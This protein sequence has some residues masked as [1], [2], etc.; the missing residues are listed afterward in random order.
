MTVGRRAA[1]FPP[2]SDEIV[3]RWSKYG[4]WERVYFPSLIGM[5]I[6]EVRT[7]YCRMRLPFRD[8]LEQ[9]AG[10]VHGGAIASLLDSVVVPAVGGAYG[11]GARLSTVDMHVQ[12]M[13]AVMRDDVVA[14]GWI[15]RRGRTVV[16]CESEARAASTDKIVARALLTFNVSVP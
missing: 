13:S 10:V 5:R 9:P 2:A 12:Y 7:D 16:F 8:V 14:E 4:Q 11:P 15:V 3:A 6:E 1:D